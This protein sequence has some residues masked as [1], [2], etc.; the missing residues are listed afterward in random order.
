MIPTSSNVINGNEI[1][2][3]G[4]AAAFLVHNIVSLTFSKMLSLISA[5]K[6]KY[7]YIYINGMSKFFLSEVVKKVKEI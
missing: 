3:N 5:L 6:L 7:I 2:K 4:L 1:S